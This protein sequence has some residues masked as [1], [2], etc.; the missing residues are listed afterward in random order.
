MA[1]ADGFSSLP[2]EQ[3]APVGSGATEELLDPYVRTVTKW[4]APTAHD[5]TECLSVAIP[6]TQFATRCGDPDGCTLRLSSDGSTIS[7]RSSTIKLMLTNAAGRKW[8]VV[9]MEEAEKLVGDLD[10]TSPATL[11]AIDSFG[12]QD[13]CELADDS[14]QYKLKSCLYTYTDPPLRCTLKIM[15]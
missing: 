14:G 4:V 6:V 11:V 5:V 10:D 12:L 15:D 3:A 8:S 9:R 2:L 7:M 13:W 1:A